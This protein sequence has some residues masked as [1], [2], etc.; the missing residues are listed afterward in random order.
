[1]ASGTWGQQVAVLPAAIKTSSSPPPDQIKKFVDDQIYLLKDKNNP[2]GQTAALE[3]LISASAGQTSAIFA[4]LYVLSLAA[5]LKSVVANDPTMRVRLNGAIA[6]AHVAANVSS[7]ASP[8]SVL[9][10]T[11]PVLMFLQDKN[12][13]V[14]LWGIK[15][16]RFIIPAALK[17]GGQNTKIIA[18]VVAVVQNHPAGALIQEAYAAFDPP[19]GSA[20]QAY[21]LAVQQ[22]LPLLAARIK[23]YETALP[24]DP[25][26]E[27]DPVVTLSRPIVWQ[28]PG[29][30]TDKMKVQI[31][32]ELSDLN[33]LLGQRA[34]SANSQ[35]LVKIVQLLAKVGAAFVVIGEDMQNPNLQT[36]A[37]PL[38]KL[39]LSSNGAMASGLS[40]MIYPAIIT[41]PLF[42][43]V[44]PPPSAQAAATGPASG[45]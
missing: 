1:M 33:G 45:K 44:K 18:A 23:Q 39:P 25:A 29:V 24:E 17:A 15:A 6:A 27:I 28:A 22:L 8:Q 30:L 10:L 37:T 14:V 36:A 21:T 5:D 16:A 41:V 43:D 2:P 38:S 13:A 7:G 20:P 34:Q 11:D 12:D 42:K 19:R 26:A 35:E 40:Q 32:Q 3:S 9:R 31:V 4:D